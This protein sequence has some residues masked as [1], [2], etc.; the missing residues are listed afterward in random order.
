MTNAQPTPQTQPRDRR[1]L[2]HLTHGL[3]GKRIYIFSDAE[4]QAYD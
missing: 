2:S 1:A 3:T 4:Q